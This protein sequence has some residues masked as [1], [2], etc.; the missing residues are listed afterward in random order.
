VRITN[1][2]LREISADL[3]LSFSGGTYQLQS[4]KALLC[5]IETDAGITAQVCVGNESSYTPYLKSLVRG[6][7]RELLV[8]QDP[9]RIE[10][11]WRAMLAWDKAYIDRAS[12]MMAIATVDTALWDLK[13]RVLAVPVW[14]LLGGYDPRV[15]MIGIGGYYET[16]RDRA[17]IRDEIGEYRRL[18]LAGIKFKVGALSLEE[19]AQRVHHARE[20]AGRDFAIVVDS[21]MAWTVEEAERFAGLIADCNPEWIEEPV[22]PRNVRRGLRQ[23][24]LKCGVRTGAGQSEASVFDAHELLARECVD[25]LNVTFNRGGGVTGWTRLA[26]A[27]AFSEVRMATVGEPQISAQLMAAI[28]N[29]TF[30]ECYP[31]AR[32]DPLWANLYV[33]RPSPREGYVTVSDEP[34]FGLR[35]DEQA[36]EKYAVE[37]W[38]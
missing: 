33:D 14:K 35:F 10:Q 8:G 30:A 5:R 11:H 15:R 19:D 13:G 17:G 28:P 24:R 22:N 3:P 29:R 38:S 20:A 21:N 31:D 27:A 7:F 9:L 26:A 18:G 36:V 37:A 1:V 25:V 16:S 12:L 2:Q 34:G 23:V 32:R 4:R 6:P